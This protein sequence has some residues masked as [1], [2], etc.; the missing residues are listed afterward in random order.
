[1]TG[2]RP[3]P[4]KSSPQTAANAAP[5]PSRAGARRFPVVGICA[6]VGSLA[7]L[8]E[9]FAALPAKNGMAFILVQHRDPDR[10]NT[11]DDFPRGHAV[12]IV[13]A[14]D[15]MRLERERVHVVPPGSYVA[16]RDGFLRLSDSR[17]AHGAR[18]PFDFFL[19]SL[20]EEC[21]A[22]A[23]CIV[24]PGQGKD[25]ARGM[26]A[27]REKSGLVI[28]P[29]PDDPEN[30]DTPSRAVVGATDDLVLP[31]RKIPDALAHRAQ[32]FDGLRESAASNDSDH[33]AST[34]I[35]A[36]LRSKVLEDF[37]RRAEIDSGEPSALEPVIAPEEPQSRNSESDS[38]IDTIPQPLVVL[39][40]E[41]RV[42]AASRLF[43]R[44]VARTPEDVVGR[45]F[46]LAQDG[47]AEAPSVRRFLARLAVEALPVEDRDIEIEL[48]RLGKRILHLDARKLGDRSRGEH[49]ILLTIEDVTER[50]RAAAA[51]EAA[52]RQ[53][54]QASIGKSRFLAAASHDLRQPL[55]T[56]SLL[57]GLLMK[58]LKDEGALKLLA[59]LDETV[60][61]MSGMLNS[62]LDINQLEAGIVSPEILGFPIN[63]LF[64]QL[65]T[66][67]AFH[68]EAAGLGWRVV[69][70]GQ[71]VRSDP[72]LLGQMIRNLLANAMK[73]TKQ[74][75]VL[76]GC[77]RLGG[78]L[79]I[80]VWD[81]GPGVAE[82]QL[83]AI[84][85]EFHQLD[86]PARERSRGLGLGLAIVQRL[87]DLLGHA[88]DVRS[89][90]GK[91]SVFSVEVPCG[92][93]TPTLPATVPHEHPA[94]ASRS[95]KILV[96][97]D[98]RLL[99][100]VLTLL[101]EGEGHPTLAAEDGK[102][103]LAL[104]AQ[105]TRRPDL[106][107]ADYN[108]PNGPNGL[109]LVARLRK[110]L[111]HEIPV[112]MLTADIS[113]ETLREIA[114]HGYTHLNKPVKASELVRLIQDLLGR[115]LPKARTI[116]HAGDPAE[117]DVRMAAVFVIDDD[118]AVREAMREVLEED[119]RTVEAYPTCEAFLAAY[120]PGRDACLLVDALMPGMSGVELLQQLKSNGHSLPSIMITGHGDVTMAVKAMQA[121]AADFIEKPVRREDLFASI[122]R[123]LEQTRDMA[124]LSASRHAAAVRVGS[125][126]A[127]QRQIMELVL[128]GHPSKNIAA[129]LGI[130]QRT[131]ESHRATL[132]KKTGSKSLPALIRLALSAG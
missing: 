114:R 115:P 67:F 87:A 69:P 66:Q 123:A 49:R 35:V 16:I 62:L 96:V 61:A 119:G 12:A 91:G 93:E 132:M 2:L 90:P 100:G 77:R 30:D 112:I 39:D 31:A 70:S 97:E 113:T 101:L 116:G 75:K 68:A 28:I 81:T 74:G 44:A 63:E 26:Q 57:Q 84:F 40:G 5:Q 65:K 106:V 3:V 108:L 79:R 92:T 86:N 89:R 95:G 43:Y 45:V 42:V 130:S 83:Q 118:A 80:E 32:R 17:S 34:N 99:R 47:E 20:A 13:P 9:F 131:V 56:I 60:G 125:L 111:H 50:N 29:A 121:G 10:E 98:D 105:T 72:R 109:Q 7:A 19:R 124:K 52:Q 4:L 27:I 22:H 102:A 53:A 85:E 107:I 71:Q 24:L 18:L 6:P 36:L 122:D 41:L 82:G 46:T 48:P 54:V 21:G 129:D 11:T 117:D 1:V 8:L 38:I 15:G 94:S 55:Q 58:R 51:L 78:K 23:V 88:I 73:Y 110:I 33:L 59:R 126:T 104:A 37:H 120:R 103:A 14:R 127:R 128:A 64:D 25:G 76:L